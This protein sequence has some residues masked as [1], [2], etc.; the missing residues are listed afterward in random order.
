MEAAATV[1]RALG[2]A[3]GFSRVSMGTLVGAP[4]LEREPCSPLA[5]LLRALWGLT[6]RRAGG[7]PGAPAPQ[8]PCPHVLSPPQPVR[9]RFAIED[10][11]L[12]FFLLYF[13]KH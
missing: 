4:W 7:H 12:Y 1:L 5:C 11:N 6:S 10:D 9:A 3:P 2:R 8:S 13:D